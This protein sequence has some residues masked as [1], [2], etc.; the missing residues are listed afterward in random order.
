MLNLWIMSILVS[1]KCQEV[2]FQPPNFK[3]PAVVALQAHPLWVVLWPILSKVFNP[4]LGPQMHFPLVFINSHHQVNS[5]MGNGKLNKAG[6]ENTGPSSWQLSASSQELSAHVAFPT[7]HSLLTLATPQQPVTLALI[8][9]S[10]TWL[11]NIPSSH[12][13]LK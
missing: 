5:S 7:Q 13:L 9:Q 3:S 2:L 6:Q 4:V 10:S 12:C 1:N 8:R 11:F